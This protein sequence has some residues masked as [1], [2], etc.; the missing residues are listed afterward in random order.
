MESWSD[1]RVPLGN[2]LLFI[3]L[4]R[5]VTCEWNLGVESWS[6]D[7]VPLGNLLLF[8]TLSRYLTCEWN[9]GVM[10]GCH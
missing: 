2:L 6:D 5:H 10:T 7:R 4:S 1:D 9:L 8:I 3:T